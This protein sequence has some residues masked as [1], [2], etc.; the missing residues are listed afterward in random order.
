MPAQRRGQ[1]RGRCASRPDARSCGPGISADRARQ[2]RCGGPGPGPRAR[3]R[4]GPGRKPA[5]RGGTGGERPIDPRRWDRAARWG[6]VAA[7]RAPVAARDRGRGGDGGGGRAPVDARRHAHGIRGAAVPAGPPRRDGHPLRGGGRRGG[8]AGAGC[9]GGRGDLGIGARQRHRPPRRGRRLG[10]APGQGRA[11]RLQHG[12]RHRPGP[13]R[14]CSEQHVAR[15]GIRAGAH[16]ARDRGARD[17]PPARAA[18]AAA[19]RRTVRQPRPGGA[20]GAAPGRP[21]AGGGAGPALPAHP[22]AA[23]TSRSRTSTCR[24]ASARSRP[25]ANAT[26][27][28]SGG[29]R[30]LAT[31][32]RSSRR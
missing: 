2:S 25:S 15:R 17:G 31:S 12:G 20:A 19:G 24:P 22:R 26:S 23:R 29:P 32:C 7:A 18:R 5:P 28:C 8:G 1:P 16:P 10:R 6:R 27:P 4:T 21:V 13:R 30:P 11:G 3:A 9:C 14:L